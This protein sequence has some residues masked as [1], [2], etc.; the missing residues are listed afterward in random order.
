MVTIF[1]NRFATFPKT[2]ISPFHLPILALIIILLSLQASFGQTKAGLIYKPA[3]NALGRSV[4]DPNGDGYVSLTTA[5][6]GVA[7]SIDYGSASELKMVPLPIIGNEPTADLATGSNGGASDMESYGGNSNQSCY[8]SY[9]IVNSIPY[10]VVR[11]RLGGAN[12]ATKGYTLLFDTDGVFGNQY[13]ATPKNPGFEKELVLE[14]GTSGG[15]VV[16]THTNS[17]S[18]SSTPLNVDNYSQRSIAGSNV[19]SDADYF[20]DYFIPYADLGLS[21]FVRIAAATITSAQSGLL[22]TIADFNGVD[23]RLY[24]NNTIAIFKDLISSFPGG[25]LSVIA[26]ENNLGAGFAQPKSK[27]PVV[28]G[29]IT[30]SD[31]SISGSSSEANGTTITVYKNGALVGT[32]TVTNNAWTYA[33]T[34]LV[35]GDFL[36]ARATATAKTISDLSVAIEVSAVPTCYVLVPTNLARGNKQNITGKYAHVDGTSIGANTVQITLFKEEN[37]GSAITFTQIDVGNTVYVGT[38]GNWDFATTLGASTFNTTSIVAK[39]TY[40]GCTSTIS[41]IST[42]TSGQVGT[43]TTAPTITTTTILASATISRSVVVQNIAA[44]PVT[45]ILYNNSI[46]IGRSGTTVAGGETHTFVYKGFIDGETVKARAQSPTVD[47][48]LSDPSNLVYVTTTTDQTTAPIIN[49][50]YVAGSNITVSGTSAELAGTVIKLYKV[51]TPNVQIGTDAIVNSYGAWSVTG[52]TLVAA[53]Q[54]VAI[55]RATG[56]NAS[57][58]SNTVTV[59]ASTPAAPSI[60]GTY[61]TGLTTINGALALAADSVIVYVDGARI[62]SKYTASS[63]VWSLTGI[64][65]S[66]L[67]KGARITAKNKTP[68]GIESA[69]SNVVT[70]TGV[71]S[72]LITNTSDGAIGTQ[73]AG[74]SFPIKIVAKD[75]V[76]ASGANGT[77]T[78]VTSFTGQVVMTS[79][80]DVTGGGGRTASFASGILGSHS[81]TLTTAGPGKTLTAV[82][83]DDPTATGTATVGVISAGAVNHLYLSAASDF[84]AGARTLYTVS[85]T[86]TWGNA[87]TSGAQTVNLSSNGSTGQFYA[88]SS[89]G[90]PISSVSIPNSASSITF[91][92]TATRATGYTVTASDALIPDG[93]TGLHDASDDVNVTY[94]SANK[95]IVTSSSSTAYAGDPVTINAQ[96]ADAYD[97]PVSTTGQTVTWSSTNAGTFSSGTSATD[98][99]GIATITFNVSVT[100]STIHTVT[101]TTSAIQGTSGNITVIDIVTPGTQA[102]DIVFSS[103]TKS[104][105]TATWTNGNGIRR[106][107]FI[108]QA[109]SGAMTSPV[110]DIPY[111]ANPTIGLGTQLGT[112]WYCIFNGTGNS[113]TVDGLT[114]GTDYT[115]QVFEYNG[116]LGYIRYNTAS[117]VV[118]PSTVNTLYKL[119]LNAPLDIQAGATAAYTVTLRDFNNN[120]VPASGTSQS[121]YLTVTGTTG[122]FYNAAISGT[123][124]YSVVIPVSSSSANFWFTATKPGSYTITASDKFPADGST[125][126]ADASDVIAVTSG[127]AAKYI[128]TSSAYTAN[129]SGQVTIT[130]QLADQ[131]DNAVATQNQPV[132]WSSTNLGGFSSSTSLTNGS[133]IATILFTVS[134]TVSTQH[135]VTA[136]TN[137]I[138]GTSSIITVVEA[139]TLQ[140]TN[141]LFSNPKATQMDISWTIGNGA[142][143]VVFIKQTSL[144]ESTIPVNKT[145]YTAK[146]NFGAGTQ[147]STGWFCV[148]N[149]TGNSLTVTGLSPVIGYRVQVFEYNGDAGF[150]Q[151]NINTADNN[152]ANFTTPS[153]IAN[154]TTLTVS[155]GT[156]YPEFSANVT[157]YTDYVSSAVLNM[158]VTPTVTESHATIKVNTISVN[159]GSPSQVISL[160]TG[161]N[162]ITTVVTAQDGTTKTYIITVIKADAGAPATQAT[163]ILFSSVTGSSMTVSWTIGNGS[164]RAVFMKQASSGVGLPVDNTTYQADPFFG[165]GTQI[166][167]TGWYCI[168]KGTAATSGTISGLTSGTDY[169]VQVFEFNGSDGAEKYNASVATNNPMTRKTAYTLN[170]WS[171][172]SDSDWHKS[173]NWTLNHVP[174]SGE[175]VTIGNVDM[176]NVYCYPQISATAVCRNLTIASLASVTVLATGTFDVSGNITNSHGVDGLI[177]KSTATGTGSM[178]VQGAIGS[179]TVERYT[180]DDRWYLLSP[181]AI[182]GV[183]PFLDYNKAIPYWQDLKDDPNTLT[184][185]YA[186]ARYDS[187]NNH[188]E[189]YFSD[190]NL[191]TGGAFAGVNLIAGVAYKAMTTQNS[192]NTNSTLYFKGDLNVGNKSVAVNG[193]NSW[194]CVGNPYTSAIRLNDPSSL[195]ANFLDAN[196]DAPNTK[197]ID[198]NYAAIYYWDNTSKS[199]K[200]INKSDPMEYAQVGQGFFVKGRITNA[201]IDFTPSMQIHQNANELKTAT[202]AHPQIILNADFGTDKYAT[203]IRFIEGMSSGLDV[204]YDAGLFRAA[205]GFALYTKLVEDNGVN[206]QLQCLPTNQYKDL[207]VPVGVDSKAAGEVVFSAVGTNLEAGCKMILEDRLTHTFTDLSTNTYKA[208]VV[209]NTATADRF[210]LHTS[211]IVSVIGEQELSTGKLIAYSVRNVEIRV[212]GEVTDKAVATLYNSLGKVVLTKELGAGSLNIIGLPNLGSGLYMLKIE[213]RGTS[214]TIKILIR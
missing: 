180:E 10:L 208:A 113:V 98:A 115:V 206:F 30:T 12:T 63:G 207:V 144:S 166:G 214:Q 147:I 56:K 35:A 168:Y 140:A 57:G 86:D 41:T 40:N 167:T 212:I 178:I 17:S 124:I 128:V 108:K 52:L 204:G 44:Y 132:T 60:T 64:S 38:D 133:G 53:D 2:T 112:G 95:Y 196:V 153:N 106:V 91:Y 111:T 67:Y 150:E 201:L 33:I 125:G 157:E 59:G 213:D 165:D 146:N 51:G 189:A 175:D 97:N 104:S 138:T 137:S 93:D 169:V 28:T 211:D 127:T 197:S 80:S 109:S 101:A 131:F 160:V 39:A 73:V 190:T 203:K 163:N 145:T 55:A 70:V 135:T 149:G 19:D 96:L 152:P 129:A 209:A 24:S 148:Y 54:L 123:Q 102:H 14:T 92:F 37:T 22:G 36:S 116:K 172:V 3:G 159:S 68:G 65:S 82:S 176:V 5:G 174:I 114:S 194:S 184:D 75:G 198:R 72:F 74:T 110:D 32:T 6:F 154:L 27:T 88:G 119:S 49:G 71:N 42:K 83:V 155:Q 23:D 1:K 90:S 18:T 170:T 183:S 9:R 61:T 191:G 187:P 195:T 4:L 58:N 29:G 136:T 141:I 45:L 182:Q 43:I 186:M 77:G 62:G 200:I 143:R 130:A 89:G 78:T 171:G 205:S 7:P 26:N 156:L 50:T 177:I 66:V 47:Y 121:V 79:S 84:Q 87:V 25:D 188:W 117:A 164:R 199:Y 193:D 139:P 69:S 94:S 103:L 34:G 76:V 21:T 15:I 85:R 142:K 99:S 126:L 100:L 20:Y 107:A 48:W 105:L 185:Q 120:A 11:F 179:G 16:Y 134:P 46:E 81:M 192:T 158:T 162:T 173:V 151:Y 8:I 202:F 13:P 118:N 210:F 31:T 161:K 181:P 122:G